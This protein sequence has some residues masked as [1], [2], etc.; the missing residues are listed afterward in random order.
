MFDFSFETKPRGKGE[1]N[2]D[3]VHWYSA[4][5]RYSY[6]MASKL[7]QV[8]MQPLLCRNMSDSNELTFTVAI[9]YE[10]GVKVY[11]NY[12]QSTEDLPI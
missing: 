7:V 2:H 10:N 6:T 1:G 12:Q 3:H 8:C 9:A 5:V 11:T 4:L